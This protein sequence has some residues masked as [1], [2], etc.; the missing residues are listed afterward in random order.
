MVRFGNGDD[1]ADV[2]RALDGAGLRAAALHVHEPT[3]DD[4]FL[5]KTGRSLEGAGDDTGEHEAIAPGPE[6]EAVRA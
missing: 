2:V 5:E 3:L 6:P 4:V 1:L